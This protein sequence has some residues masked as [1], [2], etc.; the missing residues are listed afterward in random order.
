MEEHILYT[1]HCPKCRILEK[2]LA[3]KGV[4]FKICDSRDELSAAKINSVPVLQLPDGT[5]LDYLA[6]VKYVNAK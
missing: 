6:A 2:K 5:K 4:S 3:D 1:T